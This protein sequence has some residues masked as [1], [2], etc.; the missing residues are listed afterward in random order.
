MSPFERTV[1]FAAVDLGDVI[2]HRPKVL[3]SLF[4]EV[5]DLIAEA[6]IR[7]VGPIHEFAMSD[8]E[9]AFRTLG[10]GR[11]IGKIALIPRADD[12]VMVCFPFFL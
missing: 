11:L 1:I 2:P 3:Q 6:K 8:V 5:M 10:S 12:M 9:T 4:T 7:P